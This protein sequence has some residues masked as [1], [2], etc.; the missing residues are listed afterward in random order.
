MNPDDEKKVTKIHE[1]M[2]EGKFLEQ[3][4]KNSIII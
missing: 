1:L 3:K 4:D 2:I